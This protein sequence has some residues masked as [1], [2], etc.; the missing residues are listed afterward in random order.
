MNLP[1]FIVT[2]DDVE[3]KKPDIEPLVVALKRLGVKPNEV[4][5]IG[6]SVQDAT[7]CQRMGVMF[8]AKIGGI[9]TENQLRKY[10][11]IFV[12]KDFEEIK[13]FIELFS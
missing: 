1:N 10:N 5:F 3:H 4:I 7:M 9:S 11:P 8:I 2:S 12:A 13:R 6:D